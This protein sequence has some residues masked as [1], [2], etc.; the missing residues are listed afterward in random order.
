MKEIK[1]ERGSLQ[2]LVEQQSN[3]GFLGL[4]F[5]SMRRRV[6][7][8]SARQYNNVVM[9][10]DNGTALTVLLPKALAR[11]WAP[12]TLIS[13]HERFSSVSIYVENEDVKDREEK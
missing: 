10:S 8:V 11:Y 2:N 12:L 3:L 9:R 13:F 5:R 4:Q 7:E 6:S 1:T